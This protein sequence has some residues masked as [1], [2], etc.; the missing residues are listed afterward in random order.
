[1]ST[2]TITSASTASAT[3]ASAP[4][5]GAGITEIRL[6]EDADAYHAHHGIAFG[7]LETFAPSMGGTPADFHLTKF[8]GLGKND[9]PA[10]ALGRAY[11]TLLLEGEA[12]FNKRYAVA[13]LGMKFNTGAG[14]AWQAAAEKDGREVI[15]SDEYE[16]MQ[17]MRTSFRARADVIAILE[18][19][20]QPAQTEVSI[21]A[22]DPATGLQ[23]KCRPDILSANR[24]VH[25]DLKGTTPSW[26]STS[27]LRPHERALLE[28][29]S[30]EEAQVL[31]RW[32]PFLRQAHDA[33]YGRRLA[34]YTHVI[35]LG[36]GEPLDAVMGSIAV[37]EKVKPWSCQ[38]F[39]AAIFGKFDELHQANMADLAA[40][41]CCIEQD[42][43]PDLTIA[44]AIGRNLHR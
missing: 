23:L 31:P 10:L 32:I 16:T 41:Q 40:L 4:V 19:D 11:H 37:V 18:Q 28:Q 5:M 7:D 38:T 26:M 42:Q 14:K 43:W 44:S 3:A 6:G 17:R 9:S 20:G 22:V 35:A 13:P 36:S 34:W 1:M 2:S 15:K 24:R 33:N 21:Y 30:P 12:V 8:Q 25:C 29:L 39:D 27:Y